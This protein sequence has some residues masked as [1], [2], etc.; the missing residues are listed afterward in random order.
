[1]ATVVTV[2]SAAL[3][4]KA[5]SPFALWHLLSLDAPTVAALW[6]VF[7]ARCFDVR[8]PAVVPA[9]LALAVWMFYAADRVSDAAR[10]ERDAVAIHALAE[11]HVFHHRYR[12][13]F[14]VGGAA[15]LPLLFTLMTGLPAGVRNAWLLLAVPLL[16]YVLAVHALHLHHVP[17][18]PLVGVFFAAATALPVWIFGHVSLHVLA[19]AAI[20]F[21]FLCW[22]NCIAIARWESTPP[23]AMDWCT[24]L[25]ARHLEQAA[26]LAGLLAATLMYAST[27]HT[28]AALA[29]FLSAGAILLL[30]QLRERVGQTHLRALA[31]AA[32]LTP[33]AVWPLFWLLT[34]R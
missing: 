25:L 17:K 18:E 33:F 27:R 19:P 1:M 2:P 23:D 12:Y 31:D 4:A 32:L 5:H 14:V 26:A 15:S 7:L 28:A 11:R 3:P 13:A 29:A 8:L 22:L 30:D 9:A 16:L 10:G 34:P 24:G 20:A 6:C 21:G